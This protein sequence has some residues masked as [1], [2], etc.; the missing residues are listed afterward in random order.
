VRYVISLVKDGEEDKL[1][2]LSGD[3]V[4]KDDLICVSDMRLA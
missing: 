2:S 3:C 1:M 4:C